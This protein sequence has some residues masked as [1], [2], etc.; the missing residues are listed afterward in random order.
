[1]QLLNRAYLKIYFLVLLLYV[2]FNKGVAYSY[3]A[4]ILLI[5]GIF[6]YM[7]FIFD[8]LEL[9][10]TVYLNVPDPSKFMDKSSIISTHEHSITSKGK[11]QIAFN[12]LFI[13][14]I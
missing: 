8:L 6:T 12:Q 3:M 4:E 9:K 11:I 14:S 10:L 5:A 13:L 7:V 1:M 2:F